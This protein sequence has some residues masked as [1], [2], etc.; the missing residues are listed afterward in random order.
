MEGWRHRFWVSKLTNL[1]VTPDSTLRGGLLL[2]KPWAPV[3]KDLKVKAHILC[4]LDLCYTWYDCSHHKVL[5]HLLQ[6]IVSRQTTLLTERT[7][8]TSCLYLSSGVNSLPAQG[9]IQTSQSWG[10]SPPCYY[11]ACSPAALAAS[12]CPK[13]NLLEALPGVPCPSLDWEYMSPI[14]SVIR[15]CPVLSVHPLPLL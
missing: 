7:G 12:L 15:I 6:W 5:P 8:G 11:K 1:T 3:I 13:C 9:I 2:L 4:C 14:N 10:T